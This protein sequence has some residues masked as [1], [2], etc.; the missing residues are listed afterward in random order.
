[1]T[2]FTTDIQTNALLSFNGPDSIKFLQGQTTC[3]L[4][5]LTESNAIYGAFCNPKGRIKTTFLLLKHTDDSLFMLLNDEQS[6]YIREALSPYVAFYKCEIS[7]VT[8]QYRIVGLSGGSEPEILSYEVSREDDDIVVHLPG[9]P[10]RRLLITPIDSV[11]PHSYTEASAGQWLLQDIQNGVIWT[12]AND[13][14]KFLPHDVNLPGLGAVSYEK[15]CYTGQEI[16]ARM[17]YRGNPKYKTMVLSTDKIDTM[18]DSPLKAT[19]EQGKLKSVG[20][21]I[22]KPVTKG[23]TVYILTSINKDS[24]ELGEINLSISGERS[25]LCK[26][27]EPFLG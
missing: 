23:D 24:A 20:N 11:K 3:Q 26:L 14:E 2:T 25:I 18:F 15:G 5:D 16:V 19:V 17:H 22:G 10:S 1:M 8:S 12:T 7:D 4:D 27:D 6:D 21:P 9:K 13:R